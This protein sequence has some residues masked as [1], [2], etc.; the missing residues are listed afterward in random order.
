M[1]KIMINTDINAP[2]C[3]C[4]ILG[5]DDNGKQ[6]GSILVQSDWDC[7]GFA[8]AFGWDIKSVQV[9]DEHMCEHD[10]TDGTVDCKEC[11]CKAG[12]FISSAYDF[13]SDNDGAEA[14]DPGYFI[15]LLTSP[16]SDFLGV[17]YMRQRITLCNANGVSQCGTD[18]HISVDSR[19]G[20]LRTRIEVK[21]Y[22]ERFRKNFLHKVEGWSHFFFDEQPKRLYSID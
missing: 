7:P 21:A 12:T 11:G 14:D 10:S 4:E 5:F 3:P 6:I 15:S 2:C 13:L 20:L 22:R 17:R 9:D 18:G 8:R 19:F 1:P 16:H